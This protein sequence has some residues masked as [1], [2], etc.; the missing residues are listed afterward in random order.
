MMG[1]IEV[2]EKA[3][4]LCQTSPAGHVCQHC[5][6][7]SFCND[8]HFQIHRKEKDAKSEKCWPFK[9]G[10]DE[11]K[12][13]VMVASRDIQAGETILE[14]QPAVWGPNNKSKP[15]C[16]ECLKPVQANEESIVT[17]VC[18][19]CHFPVCGEKCE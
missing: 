12:G 8:D 7:V 10:K 15:V 18:S 11:V 3:C 19:K 5:K 13:N 14:E 2:D 9:I 1:I 16:L 6:N 17:S 4:F